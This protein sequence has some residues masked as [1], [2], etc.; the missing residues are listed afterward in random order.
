MRHAALHVAHHIRHR[1]VGGRK[2]VDQPLMRNVAA[3]LALETEAALWLS[4]RVGAALDARERDEREAL[5]VRLATALG[6]YWV[7]K[8]APQ[9]TNEAQECLGG[10]GY[11]EEHVLPRLCREAPVNSIWEGSGNVQCLDVLR[12]MAREPETIDVLRDE[13]ARGRGANGAFD[14]ACDALPDEISAAVADEAQARVAAE[15]MAVLLQASLLVRHAEPAVADAFI[16][17]RLAPRSLAYGSLR[18]ARAIASL[19]DVFALD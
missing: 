11:V 18:D 19:L 15:R 12:A 16:D 6:K 9:H 4:L 5:F 13:L 7:C 8:R 1:A 2:L 14:R 10:L 3:D 17:A